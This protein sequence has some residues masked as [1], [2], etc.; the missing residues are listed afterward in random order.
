M[1]PVNVPSTSW[2][3]T[4]SR[5]KAPRKIKTVRCYAKMS[6]HTYI[7]LSFKLQD[8]CGTY[9][10]LWFLEKAGNP[11]PKCSNCVSSLPLPCT[12]YVS[13]SHISAVTHWKSIQ[14]LMNL[15]ILC[16]KNIFADGTERSNLTFFKG[17]YANQVY[18]E[19]HSKLESNEKGF[20]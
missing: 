13:V 17:S 12:I 7:F 14:S 6:F 3:P 8:P 19:E 1:V 18:M 10:L 16:Q 20:N 11:S 5:V 4:S 9:N 15:H 2:V